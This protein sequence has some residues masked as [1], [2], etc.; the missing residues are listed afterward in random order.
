MQL[1]THG[2]LNVTYRYGHFWTTDSAQESLGLSETFD[3]H[4][5][6]LSAG[7]SYKRF[8][9]SAQYA[10]IAD[11]S[12]YLDYAHVAGVTARYSPWGD[13]TL[14]ANVGLYS[15][16]TV[17]T[18]NPAWRLPLT[19]WLSVTPGLSVQ[20]ASSDD[21]S[22]LLGGETSEALVAATLNVTAHGRL[23][24]LWVGGRYGDQVRLAD[25]NAATVYNTAD[26]HNYAFWAGGQLNL[27]DRWSLFLS[28]QLEG[29]ETPQS[30]VT[31]TSS[32]T[33]QMTAGVTINF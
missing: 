2:L 7:A 32:K 23:G 33:H 26:R 27:S 13:I 16:M 31:S 21:D 8:G 15:D 30:T 6:Y 10:Y 24:S 18:I 9:I 29:L 28:Y 4:E 5:L 22:L 20:V 1:F 12:G 19:S 11:G 3:Q 14:S 17:V 25:L